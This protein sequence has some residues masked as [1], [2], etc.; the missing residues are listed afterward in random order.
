[1]SERSRFPALRATECAVMELKGHHHPGPLPA[2]AGACVPLFRGP[3][4]KLVWL[5]PCSVFSQQQ[6]K[7]MAQNLKE[8][9]REGNKEEEA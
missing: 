8:D 5:T 1:M 6:M 4:C 7:L 3:P 9:S 2:E